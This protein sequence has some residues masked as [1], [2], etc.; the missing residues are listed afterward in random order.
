MVSYY[1]CS[2]YTYTHV[3]QAGRDHREPNGVETDRTPHSAM[4]RAFSASG[5]KGVDFDISGFDMLIVGIRND[6]L[7]AY[8]QMCMF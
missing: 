3:L 2:T 8:E 4:A 1:A 6:L 5:P 7:S